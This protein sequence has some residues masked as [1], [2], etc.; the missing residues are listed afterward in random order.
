MTRFVR[1]VVGSNDAEDVLQDV[2]VVLYRKLV[3]LRAPELFRPWA[4]RTA[5]RAA[6]RHVK[7]LRRLPLHVSEEA[8][9]EVPRYDRRPS[10]D[11]LAALSTIDAVSPASRAVLILHLQEEMTLAEVAA[12]LEL[13]IGTRRS[14][15]AYGPAVL[16]KRLGELSEGVTR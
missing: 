13:P 3:W 4:F 6:F 9:S 15:L 8:L 11:A 1:G 2:L 14:R 12:V 10:N 7:K 5:S 16:R